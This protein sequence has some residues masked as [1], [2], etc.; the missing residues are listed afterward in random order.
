LRIST[1]LARTSIS[2]VSSLSF[3]VPG[4]RGWTCPSMRSTYSPQSKYDRIRQPAWTYSTRNAYG[5]YSYEKP[6]LVLRTLELYLGERT[7]AR[8]LRTYHERWRFGHPSSDDFYAVANEVAG[9]DLTW[10]FSQA[11]ESPDL[12]DYAVTM[13]STSRVEAP[14]GRL[15]EGVLPE[16]PGAAAEA[17]KAPYES[18]VLVRRVG[19][20]V[21][22]VDIALK[23]EGR[24]AERVRW[25]GK[26]R[27]TRLTFVRPERLEWA[28]VDPDRHVLLDVDWLNN[29]RRV[30][31]DSRV[32]TRWS[33]R[34]LFWVQNLLAT[35]GW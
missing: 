9:Q 23:F 30:E 8:I 12:L 19:E 1:P 34:V 14:R 7:M 35:I 28:D 22:P 20:F 15:E 4:R 25:D 33:T 6:E 18:H 31:P 10:F 32:A 2:P 26:D 17:P 11:V 27:W 29:A 16:E 13:V 3:T 5:F 24:A 21:F